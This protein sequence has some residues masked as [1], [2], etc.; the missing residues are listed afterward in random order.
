MKLTLFILFLITALFGCRPTAPADEDQML[1]P[2][3]PAA[4]G[5]QEVDAN[6][7]ALDVNDVNLQ[8]KRPADWEYY[9]TEYG[10]VL[11]EQLGSV[12]ENSQLKGLFVHVW[13][14]PLDDFVLP[15][16]AQNEAL[17]I[18]NEIIA[19]PE[20][21]GS[22]R[23]SSP[24][25]FTWDGAEAAYYLMDNDEGNLTVI[26]GIVAAGNGRFVAA[27]VSAPMDEVDRIRAEVPNILDD[28]SVDGV[29]LSGDTLDGYLPDNL[30]FTPK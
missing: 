12:A 30:S 24:T 23:V 5:I 13:V 18:L 19:N 2:T 26:F 21:V 17:A 11:A 16:S 7:I 8:V 1:E 15:A 14:P 3:A 27:S 22:A 25:A 10:V 9:T 28:L 4:K 29:T 20:Y 6:H